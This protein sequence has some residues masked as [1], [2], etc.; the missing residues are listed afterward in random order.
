MTWILFTGP[1]RWRWSLP[2][3]RTSWAARKSWTCE[4]RRGSEM[5]KVIRSLI[6]GLGLLLVITSLVLYGVQVYRSAPPIGSTPQ[7]IDQLAQ[8]YGT[9]RA[10]IEDYGLFLLLFIAGLALLFIYGAIGRNDPLNPVGI[11]PKTIIILIVL[12]SVIT[13]LN[14]LA[15]ASKAI[16]VSPA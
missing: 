1:K 15:V 7:Q 5:R 16:V 11:V 3:S 14:S 12:S 10:F 2:I 4:I 6:L 13:T 9:D 8:L